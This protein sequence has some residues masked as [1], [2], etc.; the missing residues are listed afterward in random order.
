MA[1]ALLLPLGC[2]EPAAFLWHWTRGGEYPQQHKEREEG[3]GILL[4]YLAA[5]PRSLIHVTV[6]APGLFRRSLMSS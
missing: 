3:V 6:I 2:R 4:Q 5:G 1:R